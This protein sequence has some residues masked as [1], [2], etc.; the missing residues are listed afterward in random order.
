MCIYCRAMGLK[1]PNVT[2]LTIGLMPI[3][4][5]TGIGCDELW[6]TWCDQNREVIS[7]EVED[8]LFKN[9]HVLRIMNLGKLGIPRRKA[10]S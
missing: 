7:K 6:R 8:W 4:K 3:E 10:R 2:G 1:N 9:S 5:V